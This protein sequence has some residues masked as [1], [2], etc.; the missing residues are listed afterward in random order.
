M[1]CIGTKLSGGSLWL[2]QTGLVVYFINSRYFGK[3]VSR[4]IGVPGADAVIFHSDACGREWI[5]DIHI[6]S[7]I[8][9]VAGVQ[10]IRSAPAFLVKTATGT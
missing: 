1:T 9:N 6:M 4:Q 8:V 10:N 5:G 3:L 2:N 7:L